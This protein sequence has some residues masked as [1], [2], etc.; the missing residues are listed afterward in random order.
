MSNKP[1][2]TCR[3]VTPGRLFF[4]VMTSLLLSAGQAPAAP[5]ASTKPLYKTT[6]PVIDFHHHTDTPDTKA[7]DANLEVFDALGIDKL[8]VLDGGWTKGTLLEW[9]EIYKTR[10][11]RLILFANV[12]FSKVDEAS[13][14]QDLVT[15]VIAQKRL[16]V[17][18]IKIYKALGLFVRDQEGKLLAVDDERL[19]PYWEK[20][21][22]LGL[23]VLI[24]TADPKEYF[25][26]RTYNSFHYGV[27]NQDG[28]KTDLVKWEQF[29]EPQYWKDSS[30]PKIR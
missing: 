30:V 20:C 6:Y 16:G 13:F 2:R 15:E 10:P 21:G 17:Q 1:N 23:P 14:S 9:V 5:P 18:A 11:D 3:C 25:F 4:L 7:I 8:A 27:P 22:E 26:P 12:D 24:H 29:G 19:D 28:V